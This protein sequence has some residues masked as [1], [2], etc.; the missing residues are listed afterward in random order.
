MTVNRAFHE[1]LIEES[2]GS[3]LRPYEVFPVSSRAAFIETIVD[4]VSVHSLKIRNI[5]NGVGDSLKQ[6]FEHKFG[7][8]G[9][10]RYREAQRNFTESMAA[11]SI[12][13]YL[14]QVINRFHSPVH[15]PPF[16]LPFLWIDG[17]VV[18]LPGKLQIKDRHNGNILLDNAGHLIH[19]DFGFMLTNSPGGV[20][21]ENAP[22]KLTHELLE[23][24]DSDGSGK[25]SEMYDYFKLLCIRTFL[26]F[27]KHHDRI[28]ELVE[29]LSV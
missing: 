6:H 22:F 28:I 1:I 3:W 23:V 26:A 29:M 13:T 17:L 8:S 18:W 10:P 27:R 15:C 4:A 9:S 5:A 20:N 21:F 2:V 25:P 12:V 24:M 14:L 11:Y 19:I 7:Q 16:S